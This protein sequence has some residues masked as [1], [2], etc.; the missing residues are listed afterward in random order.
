MK[1]PSC[2][3]ETRSHICDRIPKIETRYI[4]TYINISPIGEGS[5]LDELH[6]SI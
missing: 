6:R 2:I 5:L 1:S 3:F 4:N